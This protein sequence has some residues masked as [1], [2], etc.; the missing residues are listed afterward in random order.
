MLAAGPAVAALAG[1]QVAA[2]A[3][4]VSPAPRQPELRRKMNIFS[5]VAALAKINIFVL[6]L[7]DALNQSRVVS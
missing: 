2:S 7:D 6:G 1:R 4:F 3:S 5:R